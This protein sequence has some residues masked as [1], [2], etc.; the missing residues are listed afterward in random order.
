MK[1][2][3]L[4]VAIVIFYLIAVAFW[5][6]FKA[7]KQKSA[8]DYFVSDKSVHWWAVCFSIVAT[9]TSALTFISVP[10][11]AYAG[12]FNFLQLAIG[13]IVGRILVSYFLLPKYYEGELLTAYAYLEKRYGSRIRKLAS[14][15][16][17]VTRML[18]D[19]VRLYATAIPL[20]VIFRGF[21]LFPDYPDWL[22]YIFSIV[23]VSFATLIYTYIGGV[24]AVIWTDVIQMFI[25]IGGGLLSLIILSGKIDNGISNALLSLSSSG[26]LDLFNFSLDLT[27]PY[28]LIAGIT[29]G[30]FLSMA[31]HGTD[32][33]MVQRLLA[34]NSLRESRKALITSGFVVFLQFAL[35]LLLGSLLY[36]FFGGEQMKSD[37][38]FPKFIINYMPS[39]VSGFII[40]GLIAAAM[41]T[42]SS[43]ISAVSSSLVEDIY[44]PYFG[45]GKADS[46][47]LKVSRMMSFLWCI[48]LIFSALIFM[49]S[50]K[51]VVE[52]G[53]TIASITYGGL[54]GI[55]LI[56]IFLRRIGETEAIV[57]FLCSLTGMIF[58]IYFTKVAWTWYTLTGV[59]ITFISAGM[60][61][62]FSLILK[63]K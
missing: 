1:F 37:E 21:N 14:V 13:Y 12:N 36:A 10:G 2:S 31:S 9:E 61:F 47:M 11:I 18:A 35:F 60:A 27:R 50:P 40:A 28:T 62:G 38:V 43:S 57:G 25:Y 29:G 34:A 59:I 32:Q 22:I 33:L 3:Y 63:H 53:L 30:A 52:L 58:V 41:S 51:S 4:D 7:G 26:K 20:A 16:F 6:I 23:V 54:L 19:G 45:S 56:G 55:F 5:G 15:V 44:K 24:R 49:N 17:T 48:V 46:Y 39:G 42:L 8:R